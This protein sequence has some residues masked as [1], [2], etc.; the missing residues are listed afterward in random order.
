MQRSGFGGS[1]G[2]DDGVLEGIVFF[3]GLNE[4]SNGGSLLANSDVNTVQLLDF[5]VTVVPSFLVEDG[6]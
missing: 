4:L 2:D 6:V 3:K 5:V 1:G